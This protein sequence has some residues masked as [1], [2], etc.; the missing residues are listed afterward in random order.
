MTSSLQKAMEAMQVIEDHIDLISSKEKYSIIDRG[1]SMA[2][3]RRAGLP[4]DEAR[5]ALAMPLHPFV[6]LGQIPP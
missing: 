3:N 2:K 4:F 6:E 5:Q 1:Y